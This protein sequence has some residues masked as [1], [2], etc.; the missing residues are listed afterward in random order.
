MESY[1]LQRMFR[2]FRQFENNISIEPRNII[3]YGGAQHADILYEI[4]EK[5]G[6]KKEYRLESRMKD[7]KYPY[8]TSLKGRNMFGLR[9]EAGIIQ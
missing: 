6:F 9:S 8:I 1:T 5:C 3:F 7:G 4:L 2:S